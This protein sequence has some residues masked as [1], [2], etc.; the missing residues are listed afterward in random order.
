MQGWER[1]SL[2]GSGPQGLLPEG[3]L[4]FLDALTVKMSMPFTSVVVV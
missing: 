3:R 2:Y 1:V 4:T